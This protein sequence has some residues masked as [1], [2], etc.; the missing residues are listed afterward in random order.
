MSRVP[1]WARRSGR[2]AVRS[3][4]I[5]TARWRDLPDFVVIGAKRCGTT[6]LYRALEQHPGMM[7]LFPPSDHLPMRKNMKGVH[8]F[9]RHAERSSAWYRSHFATSFAVERRRRRTGGP[10]VTGEASPYYLFHPTGAEQALDR[11]GDTRFILMLRNPID[12]TYSHYK[13]QVRN[14]SESLDFEAALEA[15]PDRLRGEVERI[16]SDPSYYSYVH[17]NRSY[18]TQ[19]LYGQ[20]LHPWFAR[21][22]RERFH[23]VRSEDFYADPT[24]SLRG[25][26]DFLGLDAHDFEDLRPRNVATGEA[27]PE[28]LRRDLWDLV[29][30]DVA[31]LESQTGLKFAWGP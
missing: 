26:T 21:F 22:P 14:G 1:G 13:E 30:A 28:Q 24:S 16:L 11:L 31:S 8:W 25:V 19:S 4:G 5:L 3:A 6:S 18:L 15:E 2:R 17:E 7:P 9:D 10:V 27:L 23:I 20:S 29:E 12:R